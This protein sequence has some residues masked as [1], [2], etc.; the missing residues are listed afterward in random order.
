MT[1]NEIY[2]LP[3]EHVEAFTFTARV[4][5]EKGDLTMEDLYERNIRLTN[6]A[7]EYTFGHGAYYFER[8]N[9]AHFVALYDSCTGDYFVIKDRYTGGRFWRCSESVSASLRGILNDR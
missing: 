8:L 7:I 3:M 2:I 5:E 6:A 4:S 9:K 1:T